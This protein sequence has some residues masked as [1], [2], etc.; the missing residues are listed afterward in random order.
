[1]L[2]SR[3]MII[4][5]M[6]WLQEVGE[7]LTTVFERGRRIAEEATPL[8][9][10]AKKVSGTRIALWGHKALQEEKDLVVLPTSPAVL[11]GELVSSELSALNDMFY[12]MFV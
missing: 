2:A 3:K 9:E 7:S 1:M 5:V 6:K 12:Y 11:Y 4:P 10:E 8:A